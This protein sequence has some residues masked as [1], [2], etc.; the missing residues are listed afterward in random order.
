MQ[1][2]APEHL[3]GQ[4]LERIAAERELLSA[5]RRFTAGLA[6]FV[7]FL[8]AVLPAWKYLS[9]EIA[10]SGF[11]RYFDLVFSDFHA[12]LS[13][14]KFFGMSLLESLPVL[15]VLALLGA[16]FGMLLSLRMIVKNRFRRSFN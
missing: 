13:N 9:V 14:W 2:K 15:P 8:A 3:Y 4:V 7:V 6:L 1:S 12:V 11:G 10:A 5:R 16:F